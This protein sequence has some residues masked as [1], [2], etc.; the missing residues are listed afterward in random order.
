MRSSLTV[1]GGLEI[2]RYISNYM[3]WI[4]FGKLN[5]L[6]QI[7]STFAGWNTRCKEDLINKSLK[8]TVMTYLPPINSKVTKFDTIARYLEY[9]QQLAAEANM[10]Y[11][12]ITLD[13]GAAMSAFKLLWNYPEK[14]GNVI[15]Q[16]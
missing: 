11:M 5:T 9:P 16:T 6:D 13:V 12:N 7:V 2:S 15:I 4:V 1:D 14:F 8:K 3:L 10:P